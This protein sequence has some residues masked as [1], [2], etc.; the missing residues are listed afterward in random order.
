MVIDA[1]PEE[2][3][4]QRHHW[5]LDLARRASLMLMLVAVPVLAI[6]ADAYPNRPI[7]LLVGVPPGG[8]NDLV[9]R[10]VAQ[11]LGEQL[12]QSIVVENRGGAGGNIAADYV[13]KSP[14]DGYTLFLSVIGTMAINPSLYPS[15]PF[16]SM[17]DFATISQLTSMPNVM[18]VHPSIPAKTVKEFIAYAKEHPGKIN[19]ASG[20]S[21]TATHLAA[22]LFKTMAG[23]DMVHV[24]YKGNGPATIDLLSG[25]V[26]VMFD[27]IATALPNVRDGRLRALGVSTA[28][29]S[30][31]AP[32]LPT[33][34]E[35]GLPGYD[36]TTWHGLV[37]PAG[38][39]RPIIE[40]LHDEVVKALASPAVRDKFAAA[41]IVP[42]SSTPEEFAAFTQAEINRWRGV[43]KASGATVQ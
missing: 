1:S 36:V 8:A 15:L 38:T 29:R 20:G 27:Q 6:A 9:A 2:N 22:E 41:G 34:A 35:S 43:V 18:L 30:P 16:D 39:P 40:R 33:I 31:A 25:R 11:Q 12:G 14:P 13:A 5:M 42:V 23:I 32:D 21:G 37:A 4:M 19:F 28:S 26:A 24:P 7:R 3:A 17:R 10:V